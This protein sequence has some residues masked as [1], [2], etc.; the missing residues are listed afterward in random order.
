MHPTGLPPFRLAVAAP[1]RLARGLWF[2]FGLEV[3]A[4][5][6]CAVWF[7]WPEWVFFG[8]ALAYIA[9]ATLLWRMLQQAW[10]GVLR[11][12]GQR[13]LAC[14][15]HQL[16]Q[17][18]QPA[19]GSIS[20]VLLQEQSAQVVHHFLWPTGGLLCLHFAGQ[21]HKHYAW[22]ARQD[23]VNDDW[24]AMRRVLVA[25]QSRLER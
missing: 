24:L 2:A 4:V 22:L 3:F 9:V 5:V 17:S 18:A 10:V 16:R 8:V 21:T 19:H 7:V 11:F 14:A 1:R 12:D 20:P 15:T 6:L 13:W 25:T 23:Y